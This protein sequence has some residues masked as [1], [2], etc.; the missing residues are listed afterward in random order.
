MSLTR[1]HSVPEPQ[2]LRAEYQ[3]AEKHIS[4]LS[5]SVWQSAAIIL[6]G[7][8]AALAFL[9]DVDIASRNHPQR[10]AAAVSTLAVGA[11]LIICLWQYNWC[12]HKVA[13]DNVWRRMRE[14]ERS[15][16]MRRNLFLFLLARSTRKA[17]DSCEWAILTREE[18]ERLFCQYKRLLPIR[19][20]S[21]LALTALLVQLGWLA[22][23]AFV[24]V[25][26]Y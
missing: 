18:R 13:I 22:M 1:R 19:G 2:D 9:V 24:W 5:T 4:M 16:G 17:C 23:I 11:F 10:L 7:S 26:A 21:I 20:H 15:R 6:G 25:Q 3:A 14:I 8:I 12:R